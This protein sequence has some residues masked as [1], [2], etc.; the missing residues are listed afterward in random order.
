MTLLCPPSRRQFLALAGAALATT[1]MPAHARPLRSDNGGRLAL[2][3]IGTGAFGQALLALSPHAAVALCDV[4][5]RA[6][7]EAAV[8][9]APGMRRYSDY[10]QLLRHE[11]LQG[12]IIATPD[13]WHVVQAIHACEAGLPVLI[14]APALHRLGEFMPLLNAARRTG[15]PMHVLHPGAI[16]WR[17]SGLPPLTATAASVAAAP[18]IAGGDAPAGAEPPATLDWNAWLGPAPLR[19]YNPELLHGKFRWMQDLGGGRIVGEGTH[20]FAALLAAWDIHTPQRIQVTAGATQQPRGNYDCPATV[21]AQITLPEHGQKIAWA[22]GTAQS[23]CTMT[24]EAASASIVLGNCDAAPV[25]TCSGEGCPEALPEATLAAALQVW[26]DAIAAGDARLDNLSN[27]C[28]AAAIAHLTNLAAR[29]GRPLTWDEETG[30]F[31]DD[32]QA[33][34]VLLDPA[35]ALWTGV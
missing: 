23:V 17:E 7:D 18:N 27:A 9:A 25:W 14:A 35:W 12:V 24:I 26:T 34:R 19:P 32:A 29:W 3:H 4:D 1:A 28:R 33:N 2:G 15:V 11:G 13:H 31:E 5:S 21:A 6:L 10:R 22:Q 16:A 8:H 30:R 20:A